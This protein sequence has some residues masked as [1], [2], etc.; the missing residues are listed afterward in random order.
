MVS[1][2]RSRCWR[3]P[4]RFAIERYD[5]QRGDQLPH[6]LAAPPFPGAAQ[7]FKAGDGGRLEPFG[8]SIGGRLPDDRLDAGQKIDQHIGVG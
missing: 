7:Q 6:S 4:A 8:G 3:T 5:G 2:A 1:P